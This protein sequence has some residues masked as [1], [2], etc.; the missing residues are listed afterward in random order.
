MNYLPVARFFARS[1]NTCRWRLTTSS[2]RI[3]ILRAPSFEKIAAAEAKP[4][5][6]V[7]P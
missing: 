2:G 3:Q 5:D 6:T 7:N 1:P 4:R